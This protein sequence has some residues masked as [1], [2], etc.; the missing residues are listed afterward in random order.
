MITQERLKQLFM[1]DENTGNFIRLV[2]RRG[3]GR[4]GRV[5]G[6]CNKALGYILIGVDYGMYRA[7][8]LAWLYVYGV[9]PQHDIDHINGVKTDNRIANLRD[10]PPVVNSQN[11]KKA[12]S[13]NKLGFLGVSFWQNKYRAVI[14][15]E[16]KQKYLGS[17]ETPELAHQAYVEAKRK[18][19]EGCTI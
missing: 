15:V 2:N 14:R 7:H 5:A 16:G 18:Y 17:Y 3:N 12:P 13:T 4:S 9:W 6:H 19:H 1:Y 10:V 8:R 11:L